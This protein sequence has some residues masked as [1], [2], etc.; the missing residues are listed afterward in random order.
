M[1]WNRIFDVKYNYYGY[2]SAAYWVLQ[3]PVIKV[4]IA[5]GEQVTTG[6]ELII[7]RLVLDLDHL[8]RVCE[9]SRSKSSPAF[10]RLT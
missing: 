5:R 3:L 9:G 7:H 4:F 8:E 10:L 1:I 2:V 6:K